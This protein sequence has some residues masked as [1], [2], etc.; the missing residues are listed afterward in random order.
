MLELKL[1][2]DSDL[3]QS[4]NQEHFQ[5]KLYWHTHIFMPNTW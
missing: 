3:A 1:N 2:Y 5:V 4:N